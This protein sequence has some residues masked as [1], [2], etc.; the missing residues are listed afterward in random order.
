MSIPSTELNIR[1]IIDFTLKTI[2]DDPDKYLPQIFG[3]LKL[4]MHEGIFGM[5]AIDAA[6]NWINTTKINTLLGYDLSELTLPA[7]TVNIIASSPSQTFMGDY[8]GQYRTDIPDY[9]REVVLPAFQLE[10]SVFSTDRTK[11][12]ITLKPD[13]VNPELVLPGLHV[14]DKN[15]HGF[16]IE[17]DDAVGK[18]ALSALDTPLE[19]IDTSSAIEVISPLKSSGFNQGAM[20]FEEVV[21]IDIHCHQHKNELYFLHSI[22]MWGILKYRPILTSQFGFDLSLPTSSDLQMDQAYLGN[23]VWVRRISLRSKVVYSWEG[24]KTQDIIGFLLFI[25]EGRASS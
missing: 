3:D 5:R 16:L 22:I 4:P 23:A 11:V 1:Y 14:R 12:F 10:S 7:V 19:S 24:T 17:F 9:E 21:N 20:Q 6:K 8:G 25:N 18:L 13:M 2:Y 15:G